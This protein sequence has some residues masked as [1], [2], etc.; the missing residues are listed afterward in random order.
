MNEYGV[1]NL[2]GLPGHVF[3]VNLI[4]HELHDNTFS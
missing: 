1:G 3:I 4:L 2:V